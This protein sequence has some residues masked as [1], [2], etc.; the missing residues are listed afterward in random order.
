MIEQ[1]RLKKLK[2]MKYKL[3]IQLLDSNNN[4][5]KENSC[6]GKTEASLTDIYRVVNMKLEQCL[7][8]IE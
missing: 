4:V 8:E 6:L 2:K 7:V 1:K 3:H 5:I